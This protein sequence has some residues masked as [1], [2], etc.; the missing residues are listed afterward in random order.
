MITVQILLGSDILF[1]TINFIKREIFLAT[2]SAWNACICSAG[3]AH[4][5]YVLNTREEGMPPYFLKTL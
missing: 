5:Y 1:D 3:G 4:Q 2:S